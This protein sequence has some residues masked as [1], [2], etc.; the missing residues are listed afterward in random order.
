M[1]RY[2]LI[3][4]CRESDNYEELARLWP[5]KNGKWVNAQESLARE[6]FLIDALQNL[7]NC[8]SK[9]NTTEQLNAYVDSV[10]E[11]FI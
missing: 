11:G 4:F 2:D 7:K 10:L 8:N 6:R 5:Q 3:F 1:Q 9:L